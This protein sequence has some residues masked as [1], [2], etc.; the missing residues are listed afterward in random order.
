MRRVAGSSLFVIPVLTLA[1][2]APTLSPQVL[3]QRGSPQMRERRRAYHERFMNKPAPAFE[4]KDLK[5]R[6]VGLETFRGKVVILNFWFSSCPPCRKETPDLIRL[7]DTYRDL[8]LM[9]VGIN[10]DEVLIPEFEGKQMERFLNTYRVS[11]PILIGNRAVLDA[12]GG[13]PVQPTTFLIDR[14]GRVDRIFWGAFP[15]TAF[16]TAVRPLLKRRSTPRDQKPET[17]AP[18]GP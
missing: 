15:R 6:A 14:D 17:K 1:L 3:A 4:L 2:L 10:F 13:V 16:D 9:V 7:F 18:P 5:G 8:G 11:Y 12:Y